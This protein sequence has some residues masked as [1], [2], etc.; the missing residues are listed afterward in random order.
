MTGKNTQIRILDTVA[1]AFLILV[2]SVALVARL[3]IFRAE[4]LLSSPLLAGLCPIAFIVLGALLWMLE[5]PEQ[6][7]R[8]AKKNDAHEVTYG[9]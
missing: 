4:D 9:K 1:G 7:P 8:S 3:G 2:G 6:Q 5:E